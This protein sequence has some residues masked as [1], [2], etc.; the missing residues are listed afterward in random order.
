MLQ[1]HLKNVHF[2]SYHGIFEEERILGNHF[3]INITVEVAVNTL[4]IKHINQTIDYVSVYNLVA[5]RMAIP[6]PLL[7]TVASEIVQLILA[8]FS[9]AIKVSITIDKKTPPVPSF[10]GSVGVS[11]S[12][13]RK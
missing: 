4:P 5:E 1:I 11:Y 9:L 6:T 2:F 7:E 13:E 12:L 10:Q 8:R 3:I